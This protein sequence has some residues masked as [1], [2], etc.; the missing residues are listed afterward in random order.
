VREALRLAD[1]LLEIA[2]E[3]RDTCE[4]DGCILLD[5]VIRDCAWTIRQ[6]ALRWR[7]AQDEAESADSG[8]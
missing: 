6:A 2:D 5:G 7:L 3:R 8:Q 4:N 1:E